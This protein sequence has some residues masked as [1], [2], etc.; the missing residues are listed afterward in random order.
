LDSKKI[1]AGGT[2]KITFTVKNSGKRDGDEVAQV[3]FRHVNSSV[4]QP[5]LAL[6][7]F[8]RVSVKSGKSAKVEI[9]VSANRLRYWDA[10]KKQYVVEVGE[11]E[12]LIGA[13]SDDIWL[14]LPLTIAAK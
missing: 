8:T 3:Y 14:K 13:A 9:E 11:Y 12:F 6:C 7:G 10:D 5:R 2:A 1:A 4:P